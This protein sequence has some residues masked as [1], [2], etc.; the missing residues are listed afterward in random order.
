[1]IA[2]PSILLGS[3]KKRVTKVTLKTYSRRRPNLPGTC[4]PSTFGAKELNY[5]VR[6]GNRCDLFAITT[7]KTV[8]YGKER[9]FFVL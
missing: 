2:P 7:G 4:V 8:N 6:N 3:K 9:S 1:M 5:C